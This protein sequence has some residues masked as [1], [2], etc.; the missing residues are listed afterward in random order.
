MA[1]SSKDDKAPGPLEAAVREHI[2]AAVKASPG[3]ADA[4]GNGERTVSVPEQFELHFR[5]MTALGEAL[6]GIARWLD[7]HEQ[8]S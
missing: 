2:N 6:T 4:L 1:D 8:G 7:Q 5:Y 3:T